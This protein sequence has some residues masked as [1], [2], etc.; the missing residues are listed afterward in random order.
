MATI[1]LCM[2]VKNEEDVLARCLDSVRACVDEIIVVDTGSTDATKEIARNYTDQVYDFPWIDDFAAARNFSFSKAEMD[3]C[4]WL[5]ADDVLLEKDAKQLL[6]L[7]SELDPSVSIVMM[8]YHTAFDEEGTPTFSYYRER[9]IRNRMGFVW[10][11]AVHE[12]ITPAGQIIHVDTAVTHQKLHPSDPDRNLRIFEKLRSEGKTLDPR[13]QFYYARE[14]YYHKRYE[15]ALKE[16]ASFLDSGRGWIENEIDACRQMAYC[17]YA[18]NEEDLALRDLLRSLVYDT[19]RSEVCCEIG[20]HFLDRNQLQQAVF[21]FET[22]VEQPRREQ[23]GGFSEPDSH[24]YLPYLQLCV[25]YDRLGKYDVA[26]FY[27][28]LAGECKPN[29]QA[30]QF[31]RTYFEKR[32]SKDK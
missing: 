11:G 23:S 15:D 5:D 2:I 32:L 20:K 14:L 1:S 8:K 31:N 30:V 3:Y 6:K 26:S 28:E 18:M 12:V 22:A 24:D 10:Q 13:E 7:K 29:A 17:H 16:Y 25:C 19:P 4:M 27:N 21:W 9:L